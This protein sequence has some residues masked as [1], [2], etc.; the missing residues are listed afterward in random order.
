[1]VLFTSLTTAGKKT[2]IDCHISVMQ[3]MSALLPIKGLS[4]SIFAAPEAF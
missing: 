2:C 4:A 1:M 3:E